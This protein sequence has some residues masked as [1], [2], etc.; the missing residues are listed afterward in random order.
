MGT[1][2]IVLLDC[3]LLNAASARVPPA[4]TQQRGLLPLTFVTG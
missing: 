2:P 1:L 4:S 3:V